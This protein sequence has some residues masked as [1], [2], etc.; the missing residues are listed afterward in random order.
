M[1]H[2]HN[3]DLGKKGRHGRGRELEGASSSVA[4]P[5]WAARAHGHGGGVEAWPGRPQAGGECGL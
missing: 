2:R 5:F 1:E 4:H 3:T